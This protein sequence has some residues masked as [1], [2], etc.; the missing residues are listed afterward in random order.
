MLKN[1]KGFTLIELL[2]VVAIIAILAA[3]AIPQF[4][5][6]RIK[7]YNS[8]ATADLRNGR[9]AEE[10]FYS[11]WQVYVN[12]S[13]A[14]GAGVA[15]TSAVF[16]IAIAQNAI[17][18]NAPSAATQFITGVSQNVRVVVNTEGVGSTS[19]TMATKNSSGDRCFG[20]DSNVT[21]VYWVNGATGVQMGDDAVLQAP[22]DNDDII[23]VNG[24]TGCAGLAGANPGQVTWTIL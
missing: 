15:V 5:S 2:I 4:S 23:G 11:D 9:T 1:K 3:I 16:P 21:S 13:G 6:Y 20:M 8:S 14:M 24:G 10:A 19:F 18:A 17:T 22:T 12:T 7:G